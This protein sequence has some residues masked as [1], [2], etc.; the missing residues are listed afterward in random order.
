MNIINQLNKSF[1][2]RIRLGIM[3]ILM[4]NDIIDFNSLKNMLQLTDGNLASHLSALEK[5]T[6]IQIFKNFVGKKPQTTYSATIEG[7]KAFLEHLNTLEKLIK[8][9]H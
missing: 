3:S 5:A 8:K 9:N 7:K 1:E 4:V 6:Y 2:N